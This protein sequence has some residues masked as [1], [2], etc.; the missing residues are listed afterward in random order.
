MIALVLLLA[1]IG[2]LVYLVVTY[3]PMP[4]PFKTAIIVI[5]VICLVIYVLRLLGIGDIPVPKL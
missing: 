4:Q 1:I 2:F 5:V 3:I